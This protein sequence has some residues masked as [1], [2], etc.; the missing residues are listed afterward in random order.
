LLFATQEGDWVFDPFCGRGTTG[1]AAVSLGRKFFG[2]DLY[3]EN[4]ERARK[5]IASLIS[6][7]AYEKG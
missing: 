7:P 5:N 3:A 1:I 6:G 4:V 2:I